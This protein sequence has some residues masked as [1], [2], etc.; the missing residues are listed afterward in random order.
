MVS[1]DERLFAYERGR[2]YLYRLH[3]GGHGTPSEWVEVVYAGWMRTEGDRFVY[4]FD[5]GNKAYKIDSERA[6]RVI[7]PFGKGRLRCGCIVR[8]NERVEGYYQGY[9]KRKGKTL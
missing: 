1:I 4:V 6:A 8:G 7:K 5:C 9:I 3:G 2:R